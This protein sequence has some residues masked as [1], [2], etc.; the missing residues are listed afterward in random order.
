[1]FFNFK[2]WRDQF[3]EAR[4]EKNPNRIGDLLDE[5]VTAYRM[6]LHTQ[7]DFIRIALE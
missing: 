4:T 5:I 3:E 6:T 2:S 1:M 7:D